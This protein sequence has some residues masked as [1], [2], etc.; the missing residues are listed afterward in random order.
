MTFTL[1]NA[2]VAQSTCVCYTI[3]LCL[4]IHL[5]HVSAYF[6]SLVQS[7]PELKRLARPSGMVASSLTLPVGFRVI[8]R[9]NF[10]RFSYVF[11]IH[12]AF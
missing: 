4:A 11:E 9:L 8:T 1:M 6:S 5:L 3:V 7:A 12:N 10:C 2:E